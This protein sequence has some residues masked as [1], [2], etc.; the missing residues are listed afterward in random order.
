MLAARQSIPAE[1]GLLIPSV[2]NI[3][4]GKANHSFW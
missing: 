2:H 4:L 1:T 3:Y